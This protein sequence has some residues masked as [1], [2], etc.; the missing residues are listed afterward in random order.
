M[1]WPRETGRPAKVARRAP[2]QPQHEGDQEEAEPSAEK[3]SEEDEEEEDERMPAEGAVR[4]SLAGGAH[5][6]S[7]PRASAAGATRGRG[8]AE[9]GGR[10]QEATCAP[11]HLQ[12]AS[13]AC[14]SILHINSC[15]LLLL[16][17]QR[18]RT[19]W[20]FTDAKPLLLVVFLPVCRPAADAA[21][22]APGGAVGSAARK[23]P[24]E[25]A[26]GATPKRGKTYA[27]A[28]VTSHCLRCL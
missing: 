22:D 17:L 2:Q 18:Q 27:A 13:S 12:F 7:K 16:Y 3:E 5:R 9:A 24:S 15:K 10:T 25:A 1:A 26:A 6:G 11:V 28:P 23:R 4:V 14:F 20:R 19:D 21:T 8:A